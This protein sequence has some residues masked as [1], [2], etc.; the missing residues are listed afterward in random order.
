MI[1]LSN[2]DSKAIIRRR[3]S[4][5]NVIHQKEQKETRR[6]A[7]RLKEKSTRITPRT[8]KVGSGDGASIRGLF[9][10]A[11]DS[12]ALFLAAGEQASCTDPESECKRN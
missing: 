2:P 1:F 9:A 6:T 11:G 3:C 5:G 8:L 12:G 4:H 10:A 7:E